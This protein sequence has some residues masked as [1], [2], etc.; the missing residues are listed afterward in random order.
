MKT[1]LAKEI[2]SGLD[3][4]PSYVT[5]VVSEL[6]LMARYKYDHYEMYV[7]ATRFFEYLYVWLK[8]FK[9]RRQRVVAIEFLLHHLIFVSQREMQ[10]LARFLY[11]DVIVQ[12]IL[13]E[14]IRRESLKPFDYAKA[15]NRHF[16]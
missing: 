6:D 13:E 3:L 2:L 1:D 12:D 14:I 8:Q 16:H 9:T 10:D 11:Y 5:E 4:P 15:F 7:P